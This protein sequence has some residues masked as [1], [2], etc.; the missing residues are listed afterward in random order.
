MLKITEH[1]EWELERAGIAAEIRSISVVR[2]D[3]MDRGVQF[4]ELMQHAEIIFK[5]A[6]PEKRKMVHQH[7][8]IS[9]LADSNVRRNLQDF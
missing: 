4:I 6:K 3:Y 2:D 9:N 7:S 1:A 5:N 8:R